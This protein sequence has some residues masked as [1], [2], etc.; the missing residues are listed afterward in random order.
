MGQAALHEKY[1]QLFDDWKQRKTSFDEDQQKQQ[2]SN[3]AKLLAEPDFM[4]ET[5]GAVLGELEWPLET[6]INFDIADAGRLVLLDVDLPEIEDVPGAVARLAANK[7]RLLKK[8]KS[9]SILRQEYAKHIHAIGFRLVGEVFRTLPGVAIAIVSAYSQ[10]IDKATGRTTDD[11]LYSVEVDR[12]MFGNVDFSSLEKVNPVA[13]LAAFPIQRRMTKSG[14]FKPIDPFVEPGKTSSETGVRDSNQSSLSNVEPKRHSVEAAGC[15]DGSHYTDFV[16]RVKQLKRAERHEEAIAL[17]L[18]LVEAIE[19]ESRAA[20]E[21]WGVAPWYFEQLAILYRKEKRYADEVSI[22]E[23]YE[24]QPKAPGAG[25]M[26]LAERLEK[27][28]QKLVGQ[29]QSGV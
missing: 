11:Y 4:A 26:R 9:Q 23:R 12:E 5:L 10:R 1:R 8:Q 2:S 18:K 6:M 19:E 14:V 15:V 29:R 27:A 21:G 16:E 13:A 3:E 20:G 25:P 7:R 28:R 17:L 24:A 22:L